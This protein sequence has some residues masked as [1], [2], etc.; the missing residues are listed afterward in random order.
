METFFL[1]VFVA[2]IIL[3]IVV[4]VI[5]SSRKRK[6]RAQSALQGGEAGE[7][8]EEGPDEEEIPETGI[9]AT[10]APSTVQ[11]LPP[12]GEP[13]DRS[14]DLSKRQKTP[15]T[16]VS[17][18]E[19]QTAA[20]LFTVGDM[21]LRPP[22]DTRSE[23]PPSFPGPSVAPGDMQRA[24]RPGAGITVDARRPGAGRTVRRAQPPLGRVSSIPQEQGRPEIARR[25][26]TGG[27]PRENS[28]WQRIQGLSPLRRAVLLAEILGKPK[29]L[30]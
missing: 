29:S 15:S 13:V 22:E 24:Y 10:E 3:N 27:L 6:R 16:P 26:S 7:R 4:G 5:T 21:P 17:F 25:P 28:A 1:L 2:F 11:T 23:E 12:V 9:E 18:L 19:E 8:A 14:T 20:T 30:R